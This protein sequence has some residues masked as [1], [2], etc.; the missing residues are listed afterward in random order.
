MGNAVKEKNPQSGN[1]CGK[2]K[3]TFTSSIMG[4]N[5][6]NVKMPENKNTEILPFDNA[7]TTQLITL[8]KY[9]YDKLRENTA[10]LKAI[11]NLARE[12]E[13]VNGDVILAICGVRRDTVCI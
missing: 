1:S 11:E 6:G 5:G 2:I 7:G 10:K 4:G 12:D 13:V 3:N 9:D 8:D